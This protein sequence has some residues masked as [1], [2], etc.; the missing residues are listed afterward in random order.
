CATSRRSIP[1]TCPATARR[2]A[3]NS[4][5][6]W[7]SWTARRPGSPRSATGLS[8]PAPVVSEPAPVLDEPVTGAA[9]AADL[10]RARVG[11]PGVCGATGG[12]PVPSPGGGPA[13][14]AGGP[15]GRGALG[16]ALVGVSVGAIP[17]MP[18]APRLTHRFRSRATVRAPLLAWCIAL[19]LPAAV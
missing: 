10:V 11:V 16:V 6:S 7:P 13:P 1:P 2:R 9:V 4:S 5:R 17:A 19:L 12:A 14:A 15:A 18:L 3:T 8:R